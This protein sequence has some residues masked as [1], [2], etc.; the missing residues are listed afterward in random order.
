MNDAI[1][2]PRIARG[3]KTQLALRR[4]RLDAGEN[5]L[6]WKVGFGAPAAMA[7]LA[8]KA[9]LVGFLTDR[10]L[11]ASGSLLSLANWNKPVAEPEI[12]VHIGHDLAGG[13]DRA[14]TQ[15]AIAGLGPAIELADV[16]RPPDDVESILA[17]NIYQ[18]NL[19]LG[20]CDT[21]R[22]GGRLD[23]LVARVIRNGSEI[24]RTADPQALTGELID[25]VRHVANVLA[26][27]GERLRAGEIIITGSIVPPLWVEAGE[28]VVFA[29]DPLDTISIR[30]APKAAPA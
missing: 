28:E 17:G 10:A 29:L 18:R 20:Q 22:A 8:I 2:D 25:I 23:G 19:V 12:A 21:A 1:D 9:P 13:A 4:A 6:G 27:C 5:P 15:G 26:A 24:A 16:D 30:F 11:V 3:M 14:A 7:R